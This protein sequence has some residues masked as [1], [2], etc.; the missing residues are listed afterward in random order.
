MHVRHS[1][2]DPLQTIALPLGS[3]IFVIIRAAIV[4]PRYWDSE[5]VS[6]VFSI[7][8]VDIV[9]GEPLGWVSNRNRF[10]HRQPRQIGETWGVNDCDVGRT[11]VRVVPDNTAIITS[12]VSGTTPTT[13]PTPSA[14]AASAWSAAAAVATTTTTTTTTTPTL[15]GPRVGG[16]PNPNA[17]KLG[18][19]SSNGSARCQLSIGIRIN[20]LLAFSTLLALFADTRDEI[21]HITL[22]GFAVASKTLHTKLNIHLRVRSGRVRIITRGLQKV[23]ELL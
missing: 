5:L 14:P 7:L 1:R 13:P 15:G 9:V 21:P 20:V 16:F 2:L 18:F 17:R 10:D 8:R 23:G 19:R 12:G 3:I 22:V 6:Q 4:I 11:G